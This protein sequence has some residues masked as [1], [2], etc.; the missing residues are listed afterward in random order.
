MGKLYQFVERWFEK[1][2]WIMLEVEQI[3]CC[4]R[5]KVEDWLWKNR[6][7]QAVLVS[8]RPTSNNQEERVV[9]FQPPAE[10][11]QLEND[12]LTAVR[13]ISGREF[14]KGNSRL[15]DHFHLI[16]KYQ[17][18]FKKF[19]MGQKGGQSNLDMKIYQ[20]YVL[21]SCDRM[22]E[23]KVRKKISEFL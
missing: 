1:I 18:D 19:M 14:C 8:P 2:N 13:I 7:A 21:V 16:F 9:V 20:Q 5:D 22:T 17:S 15:E 11:P 12:L 6:K 10:K 3:E 23:L 4:K